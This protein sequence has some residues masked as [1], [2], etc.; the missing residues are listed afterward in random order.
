MEHY[1]CKA[2]QIPNP[3]RNFKI[4]PIT[5]GSR[6]FDVSSQV[7]VRH[8]TLADRTLGDMQ[9]FFAKLPDFSTS[10]TEKCAVSPSR[11]REWNG[12][13]ARDQ[14]KLLPCK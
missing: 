4:D 7:V 11:I 12:I 6:R 3:A 13:T 5:T 1:L 8:R 14:V 10:L 9:R 2:I